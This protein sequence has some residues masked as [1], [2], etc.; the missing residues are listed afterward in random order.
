MMKR[1]FKPRLIRTGLWIWIFG[2]GPFLTLMGLESLG[3]A[4]LDNPKELAL[5][6]MVAGPLGFV[7]IVIGIAL[8]IFNSRENKD[9]SLL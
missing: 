2:C 6:M 5:L 1:I 3:V 9:N 8:N 4:A 7:F